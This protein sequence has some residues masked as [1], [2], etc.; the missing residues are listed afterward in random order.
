MNPILADSML[1]LALTLIGVGGAAVERDRAADVALAFLLLGLQTL[2]LAFRRKRPLLVLGIVLTA[3]VVGTVS[4]GRF[5]NP[6][7]VLVAL[8]TVAAHCQR[9]TAIRAGLI[10]GLV[11]AVPVLHESSYNP[12][13]AIFKLALLAAGWMFG[14]YL[15]EL[16]SRAARAQREKEIETRRAVAE[17]QARIARELHDVLAHSVSVI[18]VQ[19]AAAGDVFD[20]NPERARDA[21][22]S[23]EATGRQALAD[24]RRVLDGVRPV[25]AGAADLGP[26][27]GLSGIGALIDQIRSA[28]L[29]VD[30]RIEGV[31]FEVPPGIDLSAYRIVQEALTNTLKHA[32]ASRAAVVVRYGTSELALDITDDGPG[33]IGNGDGSSGRGIIGMR[34]RVALYGGDLAAGPG[35]SGGFEVHACFPVNEK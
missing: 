23:I 16:R 2:P 28:G 11:L 10:S 22:G 24:L 4:V 15:G 17:E 21:L 3:T 33:R 6:L 18:V 19:A 25:D 35:A 27:P 8:Y 31:P 29:P 13:A 7:G 26:Q 32:G 30:W 5:F 34:E 14:A 12:T 20:S 9:R 1:A